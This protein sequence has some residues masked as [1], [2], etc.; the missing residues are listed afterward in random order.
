MSVID[1]TG[2]VLPLIAL[3][4]RRKL[5]LVFTRHMGCRF[6]KEQMAELKKTLPT[7]TQNGLTA[8]VI[9]VG[10]FEDIPK[11]KAES[12]FTGEV[13]V[14]SNLFTPECYKI[15]KLANGMEYLFAKDGSQESREFLP[16]TQEAAARAE[17]KGFKDGG[18]GSPDSEFTGDTL[19]VT[20]IY[21]H[22]S[23]PPQLSNL[24]NLEFTFL[25]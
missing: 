13:Y 11:F 5:V 19:Q 3:W 4:E 16:D 9:T 15:M 22:I 10:K 2:R 17:A 21:I 1:E 14:D 25:N 23:S 8:G 7:L 12:G 20:F 24:Y 18:F 6:C